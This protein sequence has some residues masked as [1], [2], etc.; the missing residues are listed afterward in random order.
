MVHGLGY[1]GAYGMTPGIEP[2]SPAS[3]GRFLTTG[4]PEKSNF[5]FFEFESQNRV[6]RRS[7]KMIDLL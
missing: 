5:L 2:G 3:A 6:I 7:D 1:P 4:P